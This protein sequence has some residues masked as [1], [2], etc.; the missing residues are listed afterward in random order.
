M[1]PR[2]PFIKESQSNTCDTPLKIS[3]VDLLELSR[4]LFEDKRIRVCTDGNPCRRRLCPVCSYKC[5]QRDIASYEDVAAQFNECSSVT[6]TIQDGSNLAEQW[7]KLTSVVSIWFRLMK[8][9]DP[10]YITVSIEVKDNDPLWH[11]HAHAIVF[12]NNLKALG[13]AAIQC[14]IEAASFAGVFAHPQGQQF[15][16]KYPPLAPGDSPDAI[17]YVHKGKMHTG[18]GS[19]R[20]T[21][22]K[23]A[24]GDQR[25]YERFRE[26]ELFTIGNPQLR[27]RRSTPIRKS[28]ALPDEPRRSETNRK[29]DY[30]VSGSKISLAILAE[31]LGVS[32]QVSSTI[33]T[34]TGETVSAS[35]FARARRTSQFKAFKTWK[36]SSGSIH[37]TGQAMIDQT[38]EILQI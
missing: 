9:H 31:A 14:W 2:S 18:A 27:W 38:R 1:T 28:P 24:N 3:N 32:K 15:T 23:A 11:V 7:K 37:V 26:I 5:S 22:L 21:L 20:E 17:S 6:L 25:A 30:S 29:R 10:E 12:G 8:A 36:D 13:L 16:N 35:T 4:H 19:L 33:V 34:T